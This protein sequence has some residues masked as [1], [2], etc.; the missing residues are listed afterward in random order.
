MIV[1]PLFDRVLV[2]PIPEGDVSKGGLVIPSIATRSRA[3]AYGDVVATGPGRY[4]SDG[5]LIK[6]KIKVGDVVMYPRNAGAAVPIPDLGGDDVEHVIMREPE[7]FAKVTELPR[8]SA[9]LDAGGKR[10]L[11]MVP[12]SKARPDVAYENEDGHER[13]KRAGWITDS[14]A[15]DYTDDQL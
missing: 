14:E 13:A 6:V 9:L 8:R 3:F 2:L 5:E 10:L 7:I 12:D 4:N 1:T 11:E 15:A